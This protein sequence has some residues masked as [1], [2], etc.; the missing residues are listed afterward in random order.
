MRAIKGVYTSPTRQSEIAIVDLIS[1]AAAFIEKESPPYIP[2]KSRENLK[3]IP[4]FT[5]FSPPNGM[6]FN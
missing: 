4:H 5:N 1:C 3:K 6:N 2:C